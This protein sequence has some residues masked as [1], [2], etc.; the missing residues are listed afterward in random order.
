MLCAS[1]TVRRQHAFHCL[2][3]RALHFIH[4]TRSESRLGQ[5][6]DRRV[7]MDHRCLTAGIDAVNVPLGLGL[8]HR[9]Q[10]PIEIA[11]STV[12]LIQFV[13][14]RRELA[15]NAAAGGSPVSYLA[16]QPLP[17]RIYFRGKQIAGEGMEYWP[18]KDRR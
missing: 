15:W 13:E 12:A 8:G 4:R 1:A 2:C 14:L 7:R 3:K 10:T 11:K 17:V 5:R 9:P 16:A 18:K 6:I